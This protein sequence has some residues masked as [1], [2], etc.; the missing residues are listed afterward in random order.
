MNNRI[1]PD[2][3]FRILVYGYMKGIYSSRKLE[4]ASEHNTIARFRSGRLSD[5]IENLFNQLI[6]KLG[7]MNEIKIKESYK[8]L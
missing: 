3:L 8:K 5:C 4:K 7:E 6:I 1:V 2:V